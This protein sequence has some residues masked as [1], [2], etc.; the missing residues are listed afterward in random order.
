MA[1]SN[2]QRSVTTATA[3]R[4]ATTTKTAPQ[5]GSITPRLLLKLLPWV[6]VSGGTFRVNRT[7]V[8]LRKNDRLPIQYREEGTRRFLGR[9]SRSSLNAI[10]TSLPSTFCQ[11]TARSKET[12]A[13]FEWSTAASSSQTKLTKACRSS[14]SATT[15]IQ[16]AARAPARQSLATP[17]R[18]L[19][20]AR[21]AL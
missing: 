5:M 11:R 20:A 4:L 10:P 3:R 18:F 2:L 1:E 12:Q 15:K 8:E 13:T 19:A 16:S 7:K 6:Q 21:F 17:A 14:S 9:R